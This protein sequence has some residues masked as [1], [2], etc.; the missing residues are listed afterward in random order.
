MYLPEALHGYLAAESARRGV[1]MAEIARE[2][3]SEYRADHE[4]PPQHDYEALIGVIDVP[5]PPSND[6]EHVDE[7]LAKYYAAGGTWDREHGL[8]HPD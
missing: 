1:S 6:A 3:I 4:A 5:G 2:A 7:I 8:A